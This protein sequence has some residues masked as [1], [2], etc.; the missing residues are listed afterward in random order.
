MLADWGFGTAPV[1]TVLGL[2]VGSLTA[3]YVVYLRFGREDQPLD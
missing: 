3:F 2:L 1:L